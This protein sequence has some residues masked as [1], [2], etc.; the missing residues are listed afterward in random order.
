M[1]ALTITASNVVPASVSGLTPTYE[2][3]IA[4]AAI[5]AGYPVYKD[6]TDSDK[7][8]LA[9]ANASEATAQVVGIAVHSATTGQPVTY[10]TA[11][12]ISYGAIL[13]KGEIYVLGATAGDICPADDLS[14]GWYTTRL[15]HAHSTSVLIIDLRV[16]GVTTT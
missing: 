6:S 12:P 11:G 8:K 3:G 14:S 16:T 5:T 13:T 2:R 1:A 15:G 10:Q 4:G 7:L 9:D